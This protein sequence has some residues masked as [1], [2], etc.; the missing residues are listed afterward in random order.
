MK[1]IRLLARRHRPVELEANE[2]FTSTPILFS[3]DGKDRLGPTNTHQPP[4]TLVYSTLK[5]ASSE[6]LTEQVFVD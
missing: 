3:S 2:R 4:K 6:V 1:L 5:S